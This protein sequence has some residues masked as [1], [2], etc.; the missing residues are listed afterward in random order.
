MGFAP[1]AKVVKG[2]DV[3]NSIYKCG[4]NPEQ[5]LIQAEGNA[6]LKKSFPQLAYI[7][8]ATMLGPPRQPGEKLSDDADI[9][10]NAMKH[11]Q[12]E[13]LKRTRVEGEEEA[14]KLHQVDTIR[15]PY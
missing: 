10:I 13:T 6:Y 9:I 3:V 7:R 14:E 15:L 4:E 2:M 1:F 8:S 11:D 12:L 5:G